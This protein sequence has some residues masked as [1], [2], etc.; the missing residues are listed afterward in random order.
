MKKAI[1]FE[2]EV[3][4]EDMNTVEQYPTAKKAKERVSAL[5]GEGYLASHAAYP[6]PHD[7][8]VGR[9]VRTMDPYTPEQ[10]KEVFDKITPAGDWK[11]PI[12]AVVEVKELDLICEAVA[13]YTATEVDFSLLDSGQVRVQAL[14]YRMGPAGDH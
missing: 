7:L 6:A 11:G 14:G 10:M 2:R 9:E 12:D 4:V 3:L 5:V 8:H 13:H 1:R